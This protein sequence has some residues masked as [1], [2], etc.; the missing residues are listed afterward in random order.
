MKSQHVTTSRRRPFPIGLICV[1]ILVIATTLSLEGLDIARF[2]FTTEAVVDGDTIRWS[3]QGNIGNPINNTIDRANLQSDNENISPFPPTLHGV[4]GVLS[5]KENWKLRMR[6][7]ETWIEDSRNLF[8]RQILYIYFLLDRPDP[9]L[10]EE[11]EH[12]GDIIFLNT[13]EMGRAVRFGRKLYLWY[14]V[15]YRL[16]PNASFVI[17]MDDDC[18]ICSAADGDRRGL[19]A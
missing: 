10:L 1:T 11:Q 7:R 12:H 15:A 19:C 5:A 4:V 16:H 13:P 2:R 9:A 17:K 8:P 14:S 6:Q 18:V 3:S